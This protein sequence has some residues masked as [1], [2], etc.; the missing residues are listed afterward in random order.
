MTSTPKARDDR[1]LGPEAIAGRAD[2]IDVRTPSEFAEDHVP[3][4]VNCPVLSDEERA[5]VGTLH[6]KLPRSRRRSSAR[7]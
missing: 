5:I 4:A 1:R 2:V 7:R 6:A 3:G